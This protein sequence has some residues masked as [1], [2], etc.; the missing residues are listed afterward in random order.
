MRNQV[1]TGAFAVLGTAVLLGAALFIL[2]LRPGAVA[3]PWPLAALHGLLGLSGL[4]CLLLALRNS[5]LRPDHGTA[6]FGVISAV[7]I[8]VAALVGGGIFA[9]RLA[10][11]GRAGTLIGVHATLAV[12][13]FVILAAYVLV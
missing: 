8:A 6:S 10:K 12:S 7:L 5:P 3:A 2:Q 1:L 13:G 4:G 9:V 11:S